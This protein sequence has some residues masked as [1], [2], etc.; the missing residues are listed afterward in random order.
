M[1]A[2]L[3]SVLP[4]LFILIVLVVIH[5]LGHFVT[6]K[7]AGIRVLEFGIGYPPRLFAV[8]RGDTEYSVNVLPLG[9]FV[10]LLGEED[11]SDPKSL[12]AQPAS[13]RLVVMGAG[14]FMNFVLA[15]VLFSVALMIPREMGI[16]RAV[17][18]QVVPDSPAAKAGLKPGDVIQE[19]GGR[20]IE[21]V[22]DAS[23]TI[24]L[25]LGEDTEMVVRRTEP[26]TG[27]A[28]DVT[29]SVRPRWAP[30]AYEY[31][32]QPGDDVDAVSRATGFAAEAVRQAADIDSGLTEG[33]RLSIREDG[34][35]VDYVVKKDDSVGS[36]ARLLRVSEAAVAAAAGLPDQ[37]AL[38][39]GATLN[40][41]QGPTGIVIASQYP[42][43]ETGQEARLW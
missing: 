26:G 14:S 30:P 25:H 8:R 33:Q 31:V 20:E 5:E 34:E 6:A 18:A 43:T 32:V 7:L 42:F 13:T 3:S 10:R 37:Q 11:P 21:S 23:Y 17:I 16:G 12:A 27:E 39:P 1:T 9:G 24:R 2:V 41:V 15:V 19:V 35:V 22:S 38:T 29:V 36:V 4:F 40:F 28:R